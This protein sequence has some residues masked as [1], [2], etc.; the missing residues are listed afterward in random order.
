M[1]P[2]K[3]FT[4]LLILISSQ[5]LSQNL[6]EFYSVNN[7]ENV[8]FL[9]QDGK[10]IYTQ[11]NSGSLSI[12]TNFSSQELIKK[13]EG[14]RFQIYSGEKDQILIEVDQNFYNK[15]DSKKMYEIYSSK[16]GDTSVVK[17]AEGVLPDLH[18]FDSYLS[19]FNPIEGSITFK[20][21]IN[22]KD[23]RIFLN[24]ERTP[25]FSP[26]KLMINQ[27]FV[28]YTDIDND[29]YVSLYST[30]LLDG[31][32]SLVLKSSLKT[33][34]IEAC[35]FE[36]NL[37]I[38]EFPYLERTLQS[39]ITKISLDNNPNF[40]SREVIYHSESSDIGN[41]ICK[42]NGIYFIKAYQHNKNLNSTQTDIA[43]Y[44]YKSS[45]IERISNLGNVLN[46]STTD[47]RILTNVLGK[48]YLV[49]EDKKL[50]NKSLRGK[51]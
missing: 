37:Y 10:Y 22:G 24:K 4:F 27:D 29:G 33:L 20:N 46:I 38:G 18:L 25:Y 35:I 30:S 26:L 43:F 44:N 15:F 32:K 5:A 13:D 16:L 36:N 12:T 14:A 1:S 48:I 17:R 34:G 7:L 23:K 41:M 49:Y 45:Q 9:T 40:A 6:P 8:V 2:I 11:K 28:V 19:Y 3:S 42:N 51:N 50:N 39:S 31:K 21:L 47:G